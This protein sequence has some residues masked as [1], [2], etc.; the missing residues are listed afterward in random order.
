MLEVFFILVGLGLI[1]YFVPKLARA[2]KE[3]DQAAKKSLAQVGYV[4][5]QVYVKPVGNL[6]RIWGRYAAPIPFYFQV[7][8]L[9]LISVMAGE[10]GIADIKIGDPIFDKNYVV[11]SNDEKLAQLVLSSELR[12]QLQKYELVRFRSGSLDTL[13]GADYFP[14]IKNDRDFRNIWMLECRQ[15]SLNLQDDVKFAQRLAAELEQKS[16]G[17][18]QERNLKTSFFEGR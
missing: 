8:N 15:P 7:S 3:A 17:W 11:R 5:G 18:A 4:V 9:D 6:T 14:E 13:L 1:A 16:R 10:L 12:I 2:M